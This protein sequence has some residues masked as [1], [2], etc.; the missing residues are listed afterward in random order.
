MYGQV[1]H[2]LGA[3]I[4]SIH[5]I[6]ARCA[7]LPGR[8]AVAAARGR[9]LTKA[10]EEN[11]PLAVVRSGDRAVLLLFLP[12]IITNGCADANGKRRPR[13]LV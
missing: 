5:T 9:E 1:G 12:L 10:S 3:T 8:I 2:G 13:L 4:L 7:I 11:R 6:R